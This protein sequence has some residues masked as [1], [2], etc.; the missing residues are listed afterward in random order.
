MA[1]VVASVVAF[2]VASVVASVVA[3]FQ[4][5]VRLLVSRLL[6]LHLLFK[7]LQSVATFFVPPDETTPP[8]E[9]PLA[10]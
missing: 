9:D 3:T 6:Y 2:V 1:S 8:W 10:Y 7:Y 4:T 5:L